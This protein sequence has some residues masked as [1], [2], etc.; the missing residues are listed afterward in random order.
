MM[1]TGLRCHLLTFAV[2]VGLP[3]SIVAA[4]EPTPKFDS[5]LVTSQT[6]GHAVEVD[7]DIAGAK[8]LFLVVTDGGNGFACDWADWAEPRLVAADP[9][10]KKEKKL[11][12]L[13]WKSASTGWGQVRVNKNAEGG[14]LRIDGKEVPFGIGTHAN[15]VIAY[16]LPPG[17]KRFKARAGLDNGGTAQGGGAVS[18]VRFLV[19]T[20]KPPAAL[21]AA[22]SGSQ[23]AGGRDPA[24]AIANLD[25]ASGL[26]ATLF[27]A[28]PTLLSPSSIF[29][30]ARGR[31]WV[32]EV[33]NYRH[34]NGSRP[35][36]D[37]ILVLE[38]TNGDGKSDK[39]TVFHQ[40]RDVDTAHGICVLGTPDDKG[41]R[42][43]ISVGSGVYVFI[44]ENG[45]LKADR[46]ETLFTGISGTQH[47]HGI[48]AFMFGPDGKLY[49]NFG[50]EGRQIKDAAGKPIVDMAGNIVNDKR[51]PYQEGMVFRC[52]LD[53]SELETLGW[54]FR[55]NW[56]VTVD[57]FGTLW[58]SDNDDDGN[59]GVRINYVMEFGNYGYKDEFSGAGW[60]TPRVGWEQEIPL[61]HWHLNDP[62]VVPT[63]L[64]TGAGSPTGICVYEGR[65]SPKVFWDQVIHCD[66][67]PNIVR[68]YPVKPDGAGY[69]AETVNILDGK[70]DQWFRPS[71]VCVAPDGSL[72]V[73]DWYDPGVGGHRMGDIDRGRIFRVAPP[74]TAYKVPKFDYSTTETAIEALKNCNL[75]VRHMAWTALNRQ[76]QAAEPQLAGVLRNMDEDPRMR[77]RALW[78]LSK[79]QACGKEYVE[80]ALNDANADI[81][82][83][84]LRAA[85]QL[86]LDLIPYIRQLSRDKSPQVRREC[87]IA[88]RHDKSPE[89]PG[90]WAT[91]ATAYDGEDRWYLEALGIGADK[92]WDAF[93]EAWMAK[94]G[95]SAKPGGKEYP[96]RPKAARDIMWRS[97]GTKTPA[98]LVR[99]LTSGLKEDPARYLRAFDFLS[100][101][102]KDEALL[103]LAFDEH[104]G[105][106]ARAGLITTEALRRIKNLD[107]QRYAGLLAK[108]LDRCRGTPAF[109]ELVERF[110]V[111]ARYGELL[112]LAQKQ[113]D[114]EL[115]VAAIRVLLAKQQRELLE[116]GLNQDDEKLAAVT[117]RAL[118]NSADGR[119]VSLLRGFL[120]DARRPLEV[121]RQAVRGLAKTKPGADEIIRLAAAKKLDPSLHTAA[122]F[123]LHV[124]PWNDVKEQA[125][126]L[127]PV[128]EARDKQVLPPISELVKMKGDVARGAKVYATTGTCAKCHKVNGEGKE[129]G[130]DLSA[131]GAKL[132]REAFFESILYP[133][134][135]ISH[136][137]ETH[138]VQL[139]SG[140][141]VVGILISQTADSLTIVPE[142]GIRRTYKKSEVERME[143]T[144]LSLMPADLQ[145]L[146]SAQDLVDVVDYMMTLKK[147]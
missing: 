96:W 87:A 137:Y 93:L 105:D 13:K 103:R 98:L 147:K 144:K 59:R 15:S 80:E 97:R 136:N 16:E 112:A 135:G 82:I 109:V 123:E 14:P 45:D 36:G 94:V 107:T 127:F 42:V 113:P 25:V 101:P 61:R 106:D 90:L 69:K 88:L 143:K 142:D 55:N 124:A 22:S 73:A 126:K 145:K 28:E 30:D 64:L 79:I 116:R 111:A 5:K 43:I 115:G 47:D 23:E 67:G 4:A 63:M 21:L 100:G 138:N 91:L 92:Q 46:K 84:A 38:D 18:S 26:E 17:Y 114:D 48:H 122:A 6:K 141:T 70:R 81:R 75:A 72:F 31:V 52:N 140:T 3:L 53:G 29:V 95:P 41:T 78:L 134:A 71:D 60:Q 76:Q 40:G 20:E 44:D 108:T 110:S 62:G 121:R 119:T 49:F 35:A 32:C 120:D 117:A 83:T 65:L 58:Q 133:S 2:T 74:K 8:E 68:A 51:K 125:K 24:E 139:D 86:K 37:R 54:N 19:F 34:R 1:R 89:A 130:P 77:A 10:E 118:A 33:V 9:N 85:R 102:E 132:S 128:P 99:V 56:E 11:T 50:N 131:I 39:T 66:A 129:V 7:I 104:D 57:S 27:A 12:E 146:M